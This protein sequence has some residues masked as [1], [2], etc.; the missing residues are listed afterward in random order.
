MFRVDATDR[1][2]ERVVR[3]FHLELVSIQHIKPS[4]FTDHKSTGDK[5]KQKR[6]RNE[7]VH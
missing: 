5:L 4:I 7:N 6:K 3:T 2:K 1:L